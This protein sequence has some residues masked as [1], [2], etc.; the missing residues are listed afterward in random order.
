M[1]SP[2]DKFIFMKVGMHAGEGFDSILERKNEEYRKT[3]MTFW[4]YGGSTCHPLT[5]VRPF[6]AS[7]MEQGQ[8]VYLLMQEMDSKADP[9][10]VPATEYSEDGIEWKTLPSG[11]VVTGSRYAIVLGDIEKEDLL[12]PLNDYAVALGRSEGRRASK[13]IS[14]RV[15]KACLTRVDTKFIDAEAPPIHIGRKAVIKEPYAVLLR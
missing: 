3:G 8:Q 13:Y 11:I 5:Q 7:V 12:L 15:D 4:G 10:L 14:G 6:V 1:K 9:D 2:P